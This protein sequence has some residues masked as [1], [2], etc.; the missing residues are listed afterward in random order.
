MIGQNV[1][2]STVEIIQNAVYFQVQR[3]DV[4]PEMLDAF[5][6]Q[7]I[8]FIPDVEKFY[9]AN[10][11]YWLYASFKKD[12]FHKQVSE[13]FG[14]KFIKNNPVILIK[15]L[16]EKDKRI[17]FVHFEL[18]SLSNEKNKRKTLQELKLNLEEAVAKENFE[19]AQKIKLK[20]ELKEKTTSNKNR[21]N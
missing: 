13:S 15:G 16:D 17:L 7:N 21:I 19:L 2:D 6:E 18:D 12:D 14:N 10:E 3:V 1:L 11:V 9:N 20:I 5:I 4:L 8:E